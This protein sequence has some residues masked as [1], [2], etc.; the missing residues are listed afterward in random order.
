MCVELGR[1]KAQPSSARG[2]FTNWGLNGGGEK[3]NGKLAMSRKR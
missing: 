3:F 1:A 2:T